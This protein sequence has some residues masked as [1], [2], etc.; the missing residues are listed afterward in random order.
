MFILDA[1]CSNIS[2]VSAPI[3]ETLFEI[4]KIFGLSAYLTENLVRLSLYCSQG[5][6]GLTSLATTAFRV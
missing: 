4:Y 2:S 3:F 6:R 5:E 1:R